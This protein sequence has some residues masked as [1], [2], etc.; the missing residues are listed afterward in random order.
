VG[1]RRIGDK[2]DRHREEFVGKGQF[3]GDVVLGADLE[4]RTVRKGIGDWG[5][6]FNGEERGKSRKVGLLD[7]DAGASGVCY[8]RGS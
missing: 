8:D 3:A 5:K 7:Q 1:E 6:R 2:V 4:G